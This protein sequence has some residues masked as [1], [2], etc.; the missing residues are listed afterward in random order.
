M[1]TVTQPF[2]RT[3]EVFR[4][5]T[6]AQALE[7]WAQA[8]SH[9]CPR[10]RAFFA[11]GDRADRFFV[12]MEGWVKVLQTAAS[13]QQ[14]IA[15]WVAPGQFFGLAILLGRDDY[16]AT[17]LAAAPSVAL[18]WPMAAWEQWTSA[19]PVMR[20]AALRTL[21]ARLHDALDRLRDASTVPVEQRIARTLVLLMSQAGHLVPSGQQIGMPVTRQDVADMAGTTLY[22]ASR[23]MSKWTE[24]GLLGGGR[25]QVIVTKPAV[26]RQLAGEA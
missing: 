21:G 14:V 20:A 25:R 18:S 23:T 3:L 7:V 19:Y 1:D 6:E 17:A 4:D 13:G 9:S 16:P 22:T 5:L 26:L 12:L 10:G 15:H 11:Q 2:V 24:A 8:R